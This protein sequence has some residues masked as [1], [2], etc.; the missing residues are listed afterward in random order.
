[1]KI[2]ILGNLLAAVFHRLQKHIKKV[3]KM[4]IMYNNQ[5]D[6]MDS[7]DRIRDRINARENSTLVFTTVVASASLLVLAIVLQTPPYRRIPFSIRCIGFLFSLLAPLYREVTIFFYDPIDYGD[8][9]NP[10][11]YPICARL[12]RMI[13]VRY[14]LLLPILAW[15]TFD[16]PLPCFIFLNFV[17]IALAW[18]ISHLELCYS[19]RK[20]CTDCPDRRDRDHL[21]V[22]TFSLEN[23]STLPVS[24]G[25]S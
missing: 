23:K 24:I 14:F 7:Q 18:G 21:Q 12:T 17:A 20:K 19:S 16:R 3:A 1:M 25:E 13:I 5:L 2:F 15:L 10:P 22:T 8:L 9:T 6:D 11:R 4:L